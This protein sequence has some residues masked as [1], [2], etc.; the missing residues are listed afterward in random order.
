MIGDY[1][2]TKDNSHLWPSHLFGRK[3][4]YCHIERLANLDKIPKPYGFKVA[5]FPIKIKMLEQAGQGLWQ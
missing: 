2:K 5:C 1:F 3:K 4:E